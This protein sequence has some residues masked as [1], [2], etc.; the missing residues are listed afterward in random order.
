MKDESAGLLGALVGAHL[1]M[2]EDLLDYQII[3]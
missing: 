1:R 2:R 3:H